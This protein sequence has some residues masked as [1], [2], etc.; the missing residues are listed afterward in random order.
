[1]TTPHINPDLHVTP[2]PSHSATPKSQDNGPETSSGLPP[3]RTGDEPQRTANSPFLTVI[4]S[5]STPK[6]TPP[7][8][9]AR[10]LSPTTFQ[11]LTPLHAL[12][13]TH[14]LPPPSSSISPYT[15][16]QQSDLISTS[17]S[18]KSHHTA[19]S[20]PSSPT[21]SSY[22][23]MSET[24]TATRMP[25]EQSFSNKLHSNSIPQILAQP[26][27][28][29]P[30]ATGNVTGNANGDGAVAKHAGDSTFPATASGSCSM[31][32]ANWLP[33]STQTGQGPSHPRM[34]FLQ[35]DSN[36]FSPESNSR[37]HS[38]SRSPA[39]PSQMHRRHDSNP[40][41]SD[42]RSPSRSR[43]SDSRSGNAVKV[44]SVCD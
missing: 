23:G 31:S 5:Q 36:S 28:P 4:I 13:L 42:A 11:A 34:F 21:I 19:S 38:H 32:A 1:V 43:S 18:V 8:T 30:D 41:S 33:I 15:Q 17:P 20:V 25:G 6:P 12:S 14:T 7:D 24:A 26:L 37:S 3:T 2:T 10:C 16:Q 29:E 27:L 9:P 40:R 22:R 35:R 44:S 39:S